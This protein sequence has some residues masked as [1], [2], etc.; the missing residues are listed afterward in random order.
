MSPLVGVDNPS[1]DILGGLPV[2]ISGKRLLKA[3]RVLD[4]PWDGRED[5]LEGADHQL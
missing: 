3:G 2:P 1:E 4:L 5:L